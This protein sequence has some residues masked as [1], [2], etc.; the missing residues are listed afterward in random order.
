MYQGKLCISLSINVQ[1]KQKCL[2]HGAYTLVGWNYTVHIVIHSLSC[3]EK[4]YEKLKQVDGQGEVAIYDGL[5][6]KGLFVQMTYEYTA[7]YKQAADWGEKIII[8]N[9]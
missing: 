4:S 9:R 2:F 1:N 6:R 5:V 3:G 7:D 8:G